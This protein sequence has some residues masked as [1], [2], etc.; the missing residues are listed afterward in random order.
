MIARLLVANRGEIARRITRAAHSLGIETVGVFSDADA[1]AP[2]VGECDVAVRLPGVTPAETYLDLPA[3]LDAAARTGAD[4]V[5]PGYGFLAEN[6]DAATAVLEAGLTW[7][8][9][10]PAAIRTMG[11]KIAAKDL[12]SA[13]GVPAL[14]SLHLDDDDPQRWLQ[15][16]PHLG[17]PLL[18]KASA[19]G[20]GRGMRVVEDADGLLPAIEAARREAQAAFGD[21]S[22]YCERLVRGGRHVEVQVAADAHGSVVHLFERECSLQRRHQKILEE[23][24]SPGAHPEVLARMYAAAVAAARAV[25]YTNLG[26]VEFLLDD[27]GVE[28]DPHAPFYFLEMNTRLQVEHPVTE[29]VTGLDLVALQ[30]RLAAGHRIGLTQD[31]VHRRGHAVEVRLVAEDPAAGWVPSSGTLARFEPPEVPGVRWDTA[32][33]SGSSVPPHYD[34]LVAKVIG[35]GADRDEALDRLRAALRGLRVHGIATNREALLALLDDADIRAGLTT[36]DLLE[37]RGAT[38]VPEAPPEVLRRHA[39]VAVLGAALAREPSHRCVV[40]AGWRT[41][42]DAVETT[43]LVRGGESVVVRLRRRRDGGRTVA[44]DD[45]PE[46]TVLVHG[47]DGEHL[48]VELDGVRRRASVLLGPDHDDEPRT[49]AVFGEGW[50][51]EW[52]EPA[53]LPAGDRTEAAR[54]PSSPVPGTIVAVHVAPGDRVA[55]GQPLVVLEAMK[56]EHRITADADATVVEVVVSVG[57]AVDAHEVL[58]VLEPVTESEDAHA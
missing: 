6:A 54:G 4:A 33:E 22:V 40:P 28:P 27:S 42:A 11:S 38:V 1:D 17:F 51:T 52:V 47:W 49:L 9:P 21:P 2:Y 41:L 20:G 16:A 26:T 12:V 56:M 29:A 30:L 45:G 31:D 13:A 32:V 35:R 53:R 44:V 37:G 50:S 48:D 58:V 34:S 19:G 43:E 36:T 23:T 5:H 24:P 39:A 15:A 18:V 57:D 25:D 7:V 3:I 8:G 14:P 46:S 55:V 10:S